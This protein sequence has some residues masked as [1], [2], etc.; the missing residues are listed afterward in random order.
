LSENAAKN[1]NATA[2]EEIAKVFDKKTQNRDAG[3]DEGVEGGLL[4]GAEAR[5]EGRLR[6]RTSKPVRI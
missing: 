3:V 4:A 6:I 5:T 1:A 2:D